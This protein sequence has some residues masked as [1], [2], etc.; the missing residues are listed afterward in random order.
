MMV[1]LI[2]LL[3]FLSTGCSNL[4]TRSQRKDIAKGERAYND[5]QDWYNSLVKRGQNSIYIIETDTLNKSLKPIGNLLE[6]TL[7]DLKDGLILNENG[8]HT[9]FPPEEGP[10]LERY[11]T[12]IEPFREA[13]NIDSVRNILSM[14]GMNSDKI[15]LLIPLFTDISLSKADSVNSHL[16]WKYTYNLKN[17]LLGFSNGIPQLTELVKSNKY[18]KDFSI[19]DIPPVIL[20]SLNM[21]L[22]FLKKFVPSN[23]RNKVNHTKLIIMDSSTD[24]EA[25]DLWL[26]SSENNIL[27]SSRLLR[28]ILIDNLIFAGEHVLDLTENGSRYD[29][30]MYLLNYNNLHQKPMERQHSI[31]AGIARKIEAKIA[32]KSFFKELYKSLDFLF[33]HELAHIYL[34]DTF[35]EIRCDCHAF[36]MLKTIQ[37]DIQSFDLGIFN[38]YLVNPGVNQSSFWFGTRNPEIFKSLKTRQ[39]KLNE[40]IKGKTILCQ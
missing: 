24:F 31:A 32:K 3:L 21:R 27:M 13:F 25:S 16:K 29:E 12:L 20:D 26:K 34:N 8:F 37:P 11:E 6:Y 30:N 9:F 14:H 15:Y 40:L 33:L 2:I 38:K 18:N 10:K 7:I 39:A 17:E 35:N 36:N 28:A 19:S 23:S 4:Y 1:R 22:K 5:M